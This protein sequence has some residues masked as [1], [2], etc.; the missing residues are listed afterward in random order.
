MA[1]I[2]NREYADA[3]R[4]ILENLLRVCGFVTDGIEEVQDGDQLEFRVATEDS[5]RLIGRTCQTLD[6]IQFLLNRLMSRKF[7][8]A[9]YCVVDV[10]EYRARRKE[11]LV[12]DALA[13]AEQVRTTGRAWRMPLLN[14]M[15]RRVIHKALLEVPDVETHS[16]DA[17]FSGRKRV[18]ITPVRGAGQAAPVAEEEPVEGTDIPEIPENPEIPEE[19]EETRQDGEFPEAEA[20]E[21]A[22]QEAE[23]P[24]GEEKA[25]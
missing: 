13:A 6:A 9:P 23:A 8:E 11:K 25:E 15:D 14:S 17:D 1:E 12:A 3:A 22:E 7:G 19:G 10:A 18:V 16:E 2:D 20:P 4:E 5:G 24:E 21:A